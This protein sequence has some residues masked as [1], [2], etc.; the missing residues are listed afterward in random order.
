LRKALEKVSESDRRSLSSVIENVLRDYLER[1]EPKGVS[2]EKRR[3]PRK[4]VS[5]PALVTDLE[6]SVHAGTVNDISLGGLHISVPNNFQ[7]EIGEDSRISVVFTLPQSEKPLAMQCATR[8]VRR[9]GRVN[10]GA[11]LVDT[12]FHSYRTLQHY[13]MQ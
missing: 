7:Q 6:G 13:M 9:N 4:K 10:I 3:Y 2:R 5:A 1:R 11:S 8:Y 12:D